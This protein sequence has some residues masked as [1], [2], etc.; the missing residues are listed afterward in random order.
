[1]LWFNFILGLNVIFFCFILIIMSL[2]Y[3][4]I[5]KNKSKQNLRI[6]IEL[7]HNIIYLSCFS[8]AGTYTVLLD[9]LFE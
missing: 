1:M 2:S 6:K 4:T 3:I 5:P 7:Q 8:L 9:S